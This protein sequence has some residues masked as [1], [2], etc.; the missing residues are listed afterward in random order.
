MGQ[1]APGRSG[2]GLSSGSGLWEGRMGEWDMWAAGAQA[3]S[4]L[5][6]VPSTRSALHRMALPSLQLISA[7]KL[8]SAV[9]HK[10]SKGSGMGHGAYFVQ[11]FTLQTK[12]TSLAR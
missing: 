4:R 8:F 6:P 9:F 7:S 1:R 3:G 2:P 10:T 5:A 12:Y 11:R